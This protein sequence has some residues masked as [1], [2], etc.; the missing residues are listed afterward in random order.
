[1]VRLVTDSSADLP[2]E[3]LK[4]YHIAV[5]PLNIYIQG[6]EFKEGKNITSK[7]FFNKMFS[8][9]EIPKTSQPSPLA[10][11]N[12]FKQ[13]SK[14]DEI[15]C[16]TISSGLSGTYQ[17]AC[18]GKGMCD[19]SVTVF[20]TLAG[21]LG[22]GIL[23]LKAAELALKGLNVN[24]IVNELNSCLKSMNILILLNTL[25]NIVKGGRLSR[26]QGSIAK[27][28]NL[29]ILLQGVHGK[30][31][32][33]GKTRGKKKFLNKVLNVIGERKKDFSDTVFGITHVDNLAD[34]E[35][36]RNEIINRFHPKDIIINDMGATM[37]TYAGK[38][39]MIIS[40]Y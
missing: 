17:S 14:D 1:M 37:S 26:F 8:S 40:F 11:A 34:V 36:I 15:L 12:A 18:V 13:F 39:G 21:S 9:D 2:E 25:E 20:D 30:V 28:L 16:L 5:V 35:Y 31:V 6:K 3:F 29:K 33:I 38:G 23:I 22:H 19:L 4:K 27:I 7:E 10:F 32:L 24:E